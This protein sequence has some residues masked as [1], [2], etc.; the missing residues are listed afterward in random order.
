MTDK[1][2]QVPDYKENPEKPINMV[3]RLYHRFE[4]EGIIMPSEQRIIYEKLA[5]EMTGQIVLDAGCGTGVGSQILGRE[6]RFVWGIDSN[7]R[8]IEYA[9]QMFGSKVMRFDVFDLVN[10]PPR[11]RSKF[12]AIVC[13]DV[14]EH[15]D[16]YQKALDTLKTFFRPGITKLWISTPNRNHESLQKDT[17]KNEFH[18]REWTPGEYYEIL[19]KNFKYVTMFENDLSKTLDLDSKSFIILAKCEEPIDVPEEVKEEN[20]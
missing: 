1:S 16:D 20:V 14:I 7:E 9:K 10:P 17:P 18:V 11:E 12:H 2:I 19:I 6:A 13:I 5:E 4:T 3:E 8:N 15:I